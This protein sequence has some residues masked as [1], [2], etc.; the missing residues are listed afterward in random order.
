MTFDR[1]Q[2]K[3]LKF[4]FANIKNGTELT[5]NIKKLII[6]V[7]DFTS[8][9]YTGWLKHIAAAILEKEEA[10]IISVD[11]QPGAEPPFQQA[12]ANARV[13][14]LEITAFLKS[15][16]ANFDDGTVEIIGHGV[17]AHIAGY[18]GHSFKINK[19]TA[20][21]PTGPYFEYMPAIVRLDPDDANF[22][23]VLHTDAHTSKSQGTMTN[24]GHLDFFINGAFQQPHC[25][26]SN[27]LPKFTKLNRNM[28]K[29]G[30][31]IPACS[32]K[33]SFKY[34][35]EALEN[36]NC[37]F[38]GF[39]CDSYNEFLEGKCTE[40]KLPG[41]TC[42]KIAG[43]PSSNKDNF[44]FFLNTRGVG[45][46]CMNPYRVEILFDKKATKK[47]VQNGYFEIIMID[48]NGI[49]VTGYPS[50]GGASVTF[51]TNT[52][53]AMIY[54]AKPPIVKNIVEVRLKWVH[55]PNSICVLC[56]TSVYVREV[57][58]SYIRLC[59]RPLQLNK[60]CSMQYKDEIKSGSYRSFVKCPKSSK[61]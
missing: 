50:S 15:G 59:K 5:A 52:P 48:S 6:L 57:T 54:Y 13:V 26:E 2:N 55:N 36:D 4:N 49:L 14:A 60:M 42:A 58:I 11:W 22:V 27:H 9:G 35:I 38:V 45:P 1:I 32:H 39:K 20:L 61:P 53:Y 51:Q 47:I 43:I 41:S 30:D 31:I 17:G 40:C 37:E 21:D 3:F 8:N 25:N 24:M 19:I 34:Y 7:H 18:V 23:E 44:T 29:E 12:I 16:E 28:L 46:F 33:R 56:E 10:T